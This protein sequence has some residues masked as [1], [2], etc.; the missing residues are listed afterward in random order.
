MAAF[1]SGDSH[2]HSKFQLGSTLDNKNGADE[3]EQWGECKMSEE[4]EKTK[5]GTYFI[6]DS[7]S[8]VWEDDKFKLNKKTPIQ[9]DV[10]SRSWLCI[11]TKSKGCA[12]RITTHQSPQDSEFG[13]IDKIKPHTVKHAKTW[14]PTIAHRISCLQTMKQT[15]LNNP[16]ELDSYK[17]F[18][19]LFPMQSI[20]H[21]QN[22][23]QLRSFLKYH[24]RS[25]RPNTPQ[26]FWQQQLNS[27]NKTWEQV[28]CEFIDQHPPINTQLHPDLDP[29]QYL[30]V[31]LQ[32]E[33]DKALLERKMNYFR[34]KLICD[35]LPPMFLSSL[36]LAASVDYG[37]ILQSQ[38]GGYRTS[39]PSIDTLLIDGTFTKPCFFHSKNPCQR[40]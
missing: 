3:E 5:Y 32:C 24:A 39:H 19:R 29:N 2:R 30:T 11:K 17:L 9:G 34:S 38:H 13:V 14:T 1:Q 37:V 35:N 36:F 18:Q 16:K 25:L 10:I 4:K 21:F 40:S 27:A 33:N 8:I 26:N 31:L 23:T 20:A 6:V 28:E 15:L 7:R 22:Y 12:G